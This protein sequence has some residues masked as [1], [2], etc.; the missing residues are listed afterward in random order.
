[1]FTELTLWGTWGPETVAFLGVHP[2]ARLVHAPACL[3][4]GTVSITPSFVPA[5]LR[6]ASVSQDTGEGGLMPRALATG[7][8][9]LHKMSPGLEVRFWAQAL[10]LFTHK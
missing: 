9:H 8:V 10:V 2:L 7:T 3:G 5:A 6:S 4:E 1:M